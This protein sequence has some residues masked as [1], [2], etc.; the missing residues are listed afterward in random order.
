MKEGG[1]ETLSVNI[2]FAPFFSFSFGGAEARIERRQ[3]VQGGGRKR[4][5]K[6]GEKDVHKR[7]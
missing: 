5:E 1:R 6:G 3:F 7:F 2:N 4:E